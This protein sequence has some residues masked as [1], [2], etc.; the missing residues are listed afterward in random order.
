MV[1]VKAK[2]RK[3]QDPKPTQTPEAQS[4]TSSEKEVEKYRQDASKNLEGTTRV[5][6]QEKAKK[7]TGRDNGDSESV[8]SIEDAKKK[9]P[10]LFARIKKMVKR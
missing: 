3:K 9:D 2:I 4:Q 10:S 5:T 1:K 8:R 7:E 6:R